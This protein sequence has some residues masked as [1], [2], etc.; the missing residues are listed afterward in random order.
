M[1]RL[2]ARAF[3]GSDLV[4][5]AKR[6]TA[7][8]ELAHVLTLTEERRLRAIVARVRDRVIAMSGGAAT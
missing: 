5:F 6:I 7:A 3:V 2:P 1:R 8:A 4:E